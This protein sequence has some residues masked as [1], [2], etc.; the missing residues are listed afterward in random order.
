MNSGSSSLLSE[1][2]GFTS[3]GEPREFASLGE[4]RKLVFLGEK[5]VTLGRTKGVSPLS[6]AKQVYLPWQS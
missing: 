4:A 5:F 1:S 6:E 2:K 3:L